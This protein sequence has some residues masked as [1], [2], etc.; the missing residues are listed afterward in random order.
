MYKHWNTS[1]KGTIL[2]EEELA[3][4]TVRAAGALWA[5]A[6]A[7]DGV[8]LAGHRAGMASKHGRIPARPNWLKAGANRENQAR[9]QA[10]RARVSGKAEQ[11]GQSTREG[12]AV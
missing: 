4:G 10:R 12:G 3:K 5:N 9:R 7:L 11:R 8:G 1:K 2:N 6:G